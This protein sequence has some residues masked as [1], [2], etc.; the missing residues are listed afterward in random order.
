MKGVVMNIKAY[1]AYYYN[2]TYSL[3]G[4]DS[5]LWIVIGGQGRD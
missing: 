5:F 2:T 3:L 1:G 4:K